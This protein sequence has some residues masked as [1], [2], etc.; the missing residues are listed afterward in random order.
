M[1]FIKTEEQNAI[2]EDKS[3]FLAIK[4]FAGTGKTTTL[5]EFAL[6]NSDKTILYVAYNAET[7]AQ[8]RKTFPSNVTART[9][10]SIAYAK[11]GRPLEKKLDRKHTLP[12]KP[13]TI[14]KLLGFERDQFSL[15]LAQELFDIINN[16]CFSSYR[17]LSDAIP[18]TSISI[19]RDEMEMFCENIWEEMTNPD[20]RFPTTPDVY[21][22][23]YHLSNP[24]LNYDYILFDE[25]QDANPLIMD[26]ILSQKAFGAK[27]V[28][29]G[30][31]HQSIYMFR[32]AK[33]AL[34]KIRPDSELYLTKSF[35]FGEGIAEAANAVLKILKQEPR[36]LEG[37]EAI[38]DH[39]GEIDKTK[40]FA[41]ITRT[42]S[43]LFLN[44]INAYEQNKSIYFVNGFD[45]Y[46][47]RKI[48]EIEK[49]YLGDYLKIK[50]SYIKTFK[51]F[52]EYESMATYTNDKEMLYFIKVVKKYAGRLSNIIK[53]I[54]NCAVKEKINADIILS[55]AHKSKGLEFNQVILANDFPNFVDGEG[56][57]NFIM[58][59]REDEVNILYVAATRAIEKLKPNKTLKNI[60]S[61]YRKNI[62]FYE[63]EEFS[64]IKQKDDSEIFISKIKNKFD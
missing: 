20:S 33:N 51:T 14:R 64:K 15:K 57:V 3:K 53:G 16:F 55:T 62:S 49:L 61:L 31:E 46:N 13:E 54:K 41:V 45:S 37:Y 9:A 58:S 8:A 43:N 2:I 50:D 42:N 47:F 26:L 24:K 28:F 36:T 11:Y 22:K 6:A 48:L 63:S 25:A 30:D 35:R 5:K 23:Q 10:H 1:Q 59:S 39:V 27:L 60:L 17:S 19:R 52:E 32:G 38:K 21:L 4:A 34:Q 56:N 12:F 40:Q 18:F 44:A 7:A 29:V